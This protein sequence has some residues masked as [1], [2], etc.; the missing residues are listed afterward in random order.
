VSS[1]PVAEQRLSLLLQIFT[2]YQRMGELVDRE[3]ARDGVETDG[4]AVLSAIGTFGPLTV[5]EVASMLGLPLTTASDIVRRLDARGH[6]ERRQHP[7]DGRAQLLALTADGDR[8]WRA[9]WPAL[10][11]INERLAERLSDPDAV[12]DALVRL[13]EALASVLSG[14][15]NTPTP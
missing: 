1:E 11:R 6:A 2:T 8:T 14:D 15:L 10:V 7:A 13:D 12:R 3:L 4:Y 5:T 9:G